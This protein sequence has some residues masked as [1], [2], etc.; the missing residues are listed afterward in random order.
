MTPTMTATATATA[1]PTATL[2]QSW[3]PAAGPSP[4]QIEEVAFDGSEAEYVVLA[5]VGSEPLSLDGWLLGDAERPGDAEGLY[6]LPAVTLAPGG[7]YS[8]A[9]QA[10]AFY[11]N[12]RRWPDSAI[13]TTTAAAPKLVRRSD[14]ASGS[15]ALNDGGDEVVLLQPGLYLA[16]AVAFG[17]AA[18]ATLH[19]RGQLRP[20]GG[21]SLQRVPGAAFPTESDVRNRFLLAP[22]RPFEARGL[23][24]SALAAP[25]ALDGGL[26]GLLGTLGAHSN[27]TPGFSAPPHYVLA[28]AAAQGL[29]FVALAD[30]GVMAAPVQIPAGM[31]LLP[32]WGWSSGNEGAAVIYNDAAASGL[33]L[34]A[35]ASFLA[36]R[37]APIQ[38]QGDSDPHL[39]SL[40]ALSADDSRS[41]DMPALFTRWQR[42]G[43]PL[44]PAGNA[45]PDL[46]GAVAVQPRFSGLASRSQEPGAILEALASATPGW[47]CAPKQVPA[48]SSG[49]A[50]GCRQPTRSRCTLLM[51]MATA[52]PPA[53]RSGKTG[54]RS[55]RC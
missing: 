7:L 22:P 12:F 50:V 13:E 53:W 41:E 6:A 49:W 31:A 54:R 5:N 18:Y 9:R 29:H 32:A 17:D 24:L 26:V 47:P 10:E 16:D 21:Y 46:P 30:T 2:P 40:S 1:T 34:N 3:L 44:L 25:A 37:S 51:A 52:K 8:I 28:A 11:A 39:G 35:L 42:F 38:W 33:S 23:P 48:L 45:Q 14:L 43:A 15:L 19:L 36:G 4:L 20:L 55:S 27:F